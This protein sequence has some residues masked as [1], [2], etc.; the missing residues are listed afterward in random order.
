[1]ILDEIKALGFH[2]AAK[3]GI[4]IAMNDIKVPDN[5]PDMLEEAE[6]RVAVIEDQYHR[7]LITED[8]RYN[9]IVGKWLE[10]TDDITRTIQ[11]NLDRYGGIYMMATSGAKGNITQIRQM[12]GMRGLMN[13]PSGKIIEFPIKSSLR[14]GHS[15]L[16]YFIGTHGAR[17]GLADTALRTSDS[18]YLTRRLI[19][20]AQDVITVEEDCG[21]IDG[22]WISEP[23]DKS[24]LPSF[25]ERIIGRLAASP[26]A[27]PDT[28]EIIIEQNEEINEDKAE[29][30]IAAGIKS[31]Y[32][33]TPL[34]CQSRR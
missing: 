32:A 33:R 9:G 30:I 20:V 11:T 26:I 8:E 14:E 19:D 31:V 6:Q 17:K 3:S 2:Y 13:D 27:H 34:T 25:T 23:Q 12:A 18:G 28:G 16:E 29:A 5:K 4:T 15:I 21:T 10:T 7:G 24:L 1:V 22:A